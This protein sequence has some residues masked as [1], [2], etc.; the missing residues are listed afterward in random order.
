MFNRLLVCRFCDKHHALNSCQDAGWKQGMQHAVLTWKSIVYFWPAG[1]EMASCPGMILRRRRAERGALQ[2]A[3]PEVKFT[4]DTETHDPLD[5]GMYQVQKAKQTMVDESYRLW[6]ITQL[7][8]CCCRRRKLQALILK[9][10]LN[11]LKYLKMGR[12]KRPA[13]RWR[14]DDV[15]RRHALLFGSL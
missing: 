13:K 3:S 6:A 1:S 4:I 15:A 14:K 10:D 9:A 8:C 5:V 12:S 11:S 7:L 2:L